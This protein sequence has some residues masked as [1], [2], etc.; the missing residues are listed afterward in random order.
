MSYIK[1]LKDASWNLLSYE[2]I[3]IILN[4]FTNNLIT[5]SKAFDLIVNVINGNSS[6][7]EEYFKSKEE[8]T[9]DAKSIS[10]RETEVVS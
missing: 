5:K 9:E 3:K 10:E 7:I 1:A 8:K 4:D 6:V 2:V